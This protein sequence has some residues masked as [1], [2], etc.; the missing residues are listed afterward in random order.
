MNN[1]QMRTKDITTMALLIALTTIMTMVVSIPSLATKG[2]V[3]LGDVAVFLSAALLGR[4]RGFI[5]GGVG[6]A[7]ADFLLGYTH[8]VPI[9]FIVKGIEAFLA[10]TLMEKGLGGS[11]RVFA[12]AIGG[13]W[14]ALG[15]YIMQI[16]IYGAKAALS[17][18][19]GNIFQGLV[20]AIIGAIIV[21]ALSKVSYINDNFDIR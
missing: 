10:A 5:V 19:P 20:G 2:Y 21:T 17:S 7:L 15:Y 12:M 18:V 1:N 6:S 4:K 16:P 3:N 13:L 8:Y 9:T 14:M 11:K